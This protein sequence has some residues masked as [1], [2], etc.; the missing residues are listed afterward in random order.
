MMVVIGFLCG[1]VVADVV[2][3]IE[4]G[5]LARQSPGFEMLCFG[6]FF[7]EM[8]LKV[9]VYGWKRYWGGHKTEFF[10]LVVQTVPCLLYLAYIGKEDKMIDK[11]S[12]LP[13]F[14]AFLVVYFWLLQIPTLFRILRFINIVPQLR[15]I[16]TTFITMF[17]LS[18]KLIYF[19]FCVSYILSL[20]GMQLYG[21]ISFGS[22]FDRVYEMRDMS[23][24]F[25][26]FVEVIYSGEVTFAAFYYETM[27]GNRWVWAFFVVV[28][29][30]LVII[31]YDLVISYAV[32]IFMLE[33]QK[34][35]EKPKRGNH[36]KFT[37][38]VAYFTGS[39]IPSTVDRE[40]IDIVEAKVQGFYGGPS[41]KAEIMRYIFENKTDILEN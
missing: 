16:F 26:F 19:V 8:L 35:F 17:Q 40:N 32:D 12:S 13:P 25:F 7:L 21:E 38:S 11:T 9:T 39:A 31:C 20:I 29:I 28:Y 34:Q 1:M 24:A 4:E 33:L 2:T 22:I 30:A 23:G 15:L 5:E 10:V 14:V 27:V 41:H 18:Y 3:L 37:G 36:Y 6:I